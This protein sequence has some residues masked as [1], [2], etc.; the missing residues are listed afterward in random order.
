MKKKF[1]FRIHYNEEDKI[2]YVDLVDFPGNS[3][4][5]C[6]TYGDTPEHARKMAKECIE[7]LLF[8]FLKHGEPIPTQEGIDKHG[9]EAIEIDER[10]AFALWLQQQR[11][12]RS[13]SQADF[14][15]L[16][17][18]NVK[19]YQRLENPKRCNP[20]MQTLAKIRDCLGLQQIAI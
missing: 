8:S 7:G 20:T 2:Y 14:A 1:Y 4:G 16:L 15:R 19:N 17:G 10:L 18:T 11:R 9:L 12:E 6:A 13:L 3:R 5:E